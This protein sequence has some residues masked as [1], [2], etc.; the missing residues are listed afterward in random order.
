MFLIYV[1]LVG[2]CRLGYFMR[3]GANNLVNIGQIVGG[4]PEAPRSLSSLSSFS[5][6]FLSFFLSFPLWSCLFLFSPLLPLACSFLSRSPPLFSFCL[7]CLALLLVSCLCSLRGL[8]VSLS[9][10]VLCLSVLVPW[11]CSCLSLP[12]PG[13]A[14][15]VG[16]WNVESL[17]GRS[18]ELVE[19]LGE[20]RIDIACVQE[21]R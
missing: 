13:W 2:S 18:G 8:S 6:S 5:L 9:F 7:S 4:E 3:C 21:I 19:A 1:L 11:C 16:T 12:P 20:R 17:T 10:R 15:R 14:F